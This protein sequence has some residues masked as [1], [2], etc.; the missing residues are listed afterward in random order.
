[1]WVEERGCETVL[2]RSVLK[3]KQGL[4]THEPEELVFLG[5]AVLPLEPNLVP[6]KPHAV[7]QISTRQHGG[8]IPNGT[9]AVTA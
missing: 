2:G 4:N 6:V 3:P 5:I 7:L 1:M 9:E 8:R